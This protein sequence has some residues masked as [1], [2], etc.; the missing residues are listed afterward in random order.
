MGDGERWQ[1]K[2]KHLKKHIL[3]GKI[4][5]ASLQ[6]IKWYVPYILNVLKALG[7]EIGKKLHDIWGSGSDSP[8]KPAKF[9]RIK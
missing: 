6:T 8:Q 7:R 3:G 2:W 5:Q 1:I 9:Q 4:T